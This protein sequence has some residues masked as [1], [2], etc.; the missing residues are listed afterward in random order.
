MKKNSGTITRLLSFAFQYKGCFVFACLF[1]LLSVLANLLAPKLI[2]NATDAMI[3]GIGNV[4]FGPVIQ[5]LI[6]LAASYVI[7]SVS[8][9]LLSY[10]M[11]LIANKT[12]RD[13]RNKLFEKLNQFRL[14]FFDTHPHG[15]VISRFIN[16][17]DMI[18]DGLLQS[19][20]QLI[21][22]IIT[23]LGAIGFMFYINLAMALV[24]LA[25]APIAYF[26][27]RFITKRTH[28]MFK[29]QSD[30]LGELNGYAEELIGGQKIMTAFHYQEQAYHRFQN[31]N[32]RLYD[33]GVKAQFYSSMPNPTTRYV[34]NIT[35][36]AVGI[37]GCISATFGHVSVGDIASFLIYANVFAKPFNEISGVVTQ[38]QTAVAS[39]E[40]VFAILD[41]DVQT[42]DNP[43]ATVLGADCKGRVTFEHVYF[44]YVPSKPLI[45][46]FNIDVPPGSRVA[47]VGSTGAGKTTIVNLLM[48]FYEVDRGRILVDGTDIREIT[49]DSLRRNFGMV[50]QDT[51]LFA[52]TIRDNIAYGKPDASEEEIIAAAK[53]AHAHSFIKRLPEGYDTL[54]TDA[55]ENISQGERQLLTIARVML[56]DPPMLI[57]DEATSNI[58][59]ITELR[60]QKAF[61]KMMEG[62]TSFVIAHRLSTIKEADNIL[63]MEHGNVVESGTHAELLK[64]GGVYYQLYNS[65]FAP[66]DEKD[67]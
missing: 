11:T 50:L 65:Q 47:I 34:N 49:R 35:Y 4:Q 10:F 48:R 36:I 6:V 2:G 24:V 31:I 17:V 23:I 15:D 62:R 25:S 64:K 46:D 42:P 67:A 29:E 22:G 9:W 12:S 60:I 21:T 38:V 5:I 44:S 27:A 16:D 32:A 41:M 57:L 30:T 51:W 39:A 18:T 19:I 1:A 43:N 3:D 58:D 63:V 28:Q 45:Q 37:V 54:I 20:T 61:L 53:A 52:G 14:Q 33:I 56:V 8:Q 7:M 66:S 13:L 40:R 26:V 59:T 55:G